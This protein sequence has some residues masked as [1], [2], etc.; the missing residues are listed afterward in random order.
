[1]L[2]MHDR[3]LL[4]VCNMFPLGLVLLNYLD[5]VTIQHIPNHRYD[6]RRQVEWNEY[7]T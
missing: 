6:E 1:M 3:V 2:P 5:P 4:I 7:V